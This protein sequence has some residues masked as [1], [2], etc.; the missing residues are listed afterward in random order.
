MQFLAG[1]E[2]H[3]FSGSDADFG[4]GAGIATDS[5]FAGADTEDAESA[6]LN[7]FAGGQCLLEAFENRIDG[8]FGLCAGQAGAFNHVMDDVLF[9]QWGNLTDA[10]DT[11]V[12][13]LT[14]GM[15]LILARKWNKLRSLWPFLLRKSMKAA[16]RTNYPRGAPICGRRPGDLPNRIRPQQ[17]GRQTGALTTSQARSGVSLLRCIRH[18]REDGQ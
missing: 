2:P 14:G 8:C 15:L 6:Q 13:L 18:A 5:G 16:A 12:L 7:A 3:R 17:D 11:T 10:T 4:S 9:N 1:L